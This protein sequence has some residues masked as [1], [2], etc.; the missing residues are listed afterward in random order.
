[1][2]LEGKDEEVAQDSWRYETMMDQSLVSTVGIDVLNAGN[3]LGAE[4]ATKTKEK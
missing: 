2:R 4:E 1:M 3:K